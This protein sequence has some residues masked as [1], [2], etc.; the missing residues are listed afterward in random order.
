MRHVLVRATAGLGIG[1]VLAL[2]LQTAPA[3]A[4]GPGPG[5]AS[6]WSSWIPGWGGD[7]P[8]RGHHHPPGNGNRSPD[9]G[10]LY[11]ACVAQLMAPDTGGADFTKTIT[12][13]RKSGRWT[14]E[15]SFAFTTTRP[16]GVYR[17]RDCAFID[18]GGTGRFNALL[19][20]VVG[21]TPE[22]L[23][24]IVD[25]KGTSS[26]T[27]WADED[28]VV[29]DRLSMRGGSPFF[30]DRSNVA[31]IDLAE[32]EVPIGAVGGVGLVS[33]ATAFFM[34]AYLLNRRK[35]RRLRAATAAGPA[36]Y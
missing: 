22:R 26:I 19:N 12:D 27:V 23:V 32:T 18:G 9:G 28:D 30:V 34:G 3:L 2:A 35:V 25:G 7:K 6:S 16:D 1:L 4:S 33:L 15:I 5:T 31:C 11:L 20:P 10:A 29:C 24:S 8:G 14:Y 36:P 21:G 17:M 13:A